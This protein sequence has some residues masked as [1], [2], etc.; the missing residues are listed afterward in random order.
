MDMVDGMG[1]L[2]GEMGPQSWAEFMGMTVKRVGTMSYV[3]W[4]WG[5]V[6]LEQVMGRASV[7]LAVALQ[8]LWPYFMRTMGPEEEK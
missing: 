5:L 3:L 8:P 2:S 6:L 7:G 4:T 1:R